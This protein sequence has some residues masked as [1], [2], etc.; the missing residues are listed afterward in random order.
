GVERRRRGAAPHL[1]SRRSCGTP[2]DDR[3]LL[4]LLGGQ[5][6]CGV[7]DLLDRGVDLAG[8]THRAEEGNGLLLGDHDPAADLD[9]AELPGA[10]VVAKGRN[11]C[12][13][14]LGQ[15][16][17]R[18][19]GRCGHD[20]TPDSSNCPERG[21]FP[22]CCLGG[23]T[24]RALLAGGR[25]HH[26]FTGALTP[27]PASY[28]RLACHSR[29]YAFSTCR[30]IYRPLTVRSATP[31][32]EIVARI[33]PRGYPI[34]RVSRSRLTRTNAILAPLVKSRYPSSRP[35]SYPSQRELNTP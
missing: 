23:L 7:N 6:G 12:V 1:S 25:S 27:Y 2:E 17:Q 10:D 19:E 35:S 34:L 28:R 8:R 13:E 11:R 26:R 20:G 21:A 3:E 15:R 4:A 9:G 32:R 5:S 16:L 31:W 33:H 22:A 24:Y 30:R 18:Q 29:A 14:A